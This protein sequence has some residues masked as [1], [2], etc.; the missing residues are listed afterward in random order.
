MLIR[1][2]LLG[3]LFYEYIH[4]CLG[5]SPLLS[6]NI[7]QYYDTGMIELVVFSKLLSVGDEKRE[8]LAI[9]ILSTDTAFFGLNPKNQNHFRI[10]L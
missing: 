5:V 9:G 1:C 6:H 10:P 7:I 2:M 8:K 4:V 3:D